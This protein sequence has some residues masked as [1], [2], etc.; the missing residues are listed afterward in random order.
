MTF[1][2]GLIVGLLVGA[3]LGAFFMAAIACASRDDD[4]HA[5]ELLRALKK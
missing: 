5:T 4:D 1:L 3:S 2:V